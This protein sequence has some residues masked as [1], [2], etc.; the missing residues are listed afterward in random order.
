[1]DA[2]GGDCKG[3]VPVFSACPEK[4]RG[5]GECDDLCNNARNHHDDGDCTDEVATGPPNNVT[6]QLEDQV[7]DR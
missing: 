3:A 2:D 5:D 7:R 4:W 6:A 1:L